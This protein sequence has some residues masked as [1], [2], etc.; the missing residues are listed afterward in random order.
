MGTRLVDRTCGRCNGSG[1]VTNEDDILGGKRDC[2]ICKK[3]GV[4][5]VPSNYRRCPQCNGTGR[6]DIG[7]FVPEVVRCKNC[8]GT[9]WASPPPAY[10][11]KVLNKALNLM[12]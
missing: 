7:D 1:R 5:R 8:K 9:G 2:P 4:V 10:W 6:K 3:Y 12:K 11:M